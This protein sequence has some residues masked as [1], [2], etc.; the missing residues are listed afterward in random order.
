MLLTAANVSGEYGRDPRLQ[1][2]LYDH[3]WGENTIKG[4]VRHVAQGSQCEMTSSPPSAVN[5]S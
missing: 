1:S 4:F 5:R 2:L 3:P